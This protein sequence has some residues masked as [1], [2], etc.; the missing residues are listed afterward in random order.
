[1]QIDN[2]FDSLLMDIEPKDEHLAS[3][4]PGDLVSFVAD[5]NTPFYESSGEMMRL[6]NFDMHKELALVI[7]KSKEHY[8]NAKVKMILVMLTPSNRLGWVP[9]TA[10]RNTKDDA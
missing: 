6:G 5:Y 1:M 7:A 9:E 10:L 3:V 4:L 8:T 2:D